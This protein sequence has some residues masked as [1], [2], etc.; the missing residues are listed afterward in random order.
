MNRRHFVKR[1]KKCEEDETR[2]SKKE[3][4]ACLFTH[5]QAVTRLEG[6][7]RTSCEG[8]GGI[9]I[10]EA[11]GGADAQ[12]VMQVSILQAQQSSFIGGSLNVL[13]SYQC[14]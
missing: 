5:T 13:N 9:M 12:V 14:G 2:N 4:D 3:E 8:R 10:I 6:S 11:E 7:Q 1:M